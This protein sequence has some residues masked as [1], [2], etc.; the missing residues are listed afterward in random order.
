MTP[1]LAGRVAAGPADRPIAVIATLS[2]QVDGASA[3]P[4]AA[5]RRAMRATARRTQTTVAARVSG[6]VRRFWLVNAIAFS[7]TPR[8]IRAVSADPAVA[9]VALDRAVRTAQQWVP[10]PDAGGGNRGLDTIHAPTAWQRYGVTGAGVRVGVIDTGVNAAHPDLAG[11]VVAWRDFVNGRPAPYDDSGHGTHTAGIIAGG[12]AGG[13]SI[14]VAPGASLVVAKAIG[15][16]GVGSG[17]ALLAAA[18]WMADPDGD[19]AT[20]DHPAVINNSWSSGATSDAWFRTMTARWRQ[21]GITPVFAAGNSGPLGPIASPA[22]YPDVITV[23]ALGADGTAAP[24]SAR[25]PVVWDDPD[26]GGPPAGT[27]LTKPD[28]AAPG[29]AVVSSVG[30]GYLAYS[31]TSVAAPAVS[32]AAALLLQAAPALP[33]DRVAALLRSGA[34][35]IAPA[36]PDGATGHGVLDIPRTLSLAV[37]PAGTTA[38]GREP[39]RPRLAIVRRRSGTATVFRAEGVGATELR[40]GSVRWDFGGGDVTT[41]D[42]ARR[43]FADDARRRVKV[44]A[45][46]VSGTP[47]RTAMTLR[48]RATPLRTMR[49]SRAPRSSGGH[50][51]RIVVRATARR[52]VALGVSLRR[53]ETRAASPAHAT[54]RRAAAESAGRRLARTRAHA[55]RGRFSVSVATRGLAPG[56][57]RVEVTTVRRG[58][59]ARSV[60]TIAIR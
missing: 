16:D 9:Q 38:A 49:V 18:Q 53:V 48:P 30:D 20:A 17:S 59:R 24:F 27:V 50:A 56:V 34:V 11:K 39:R 12:S 21:L 5:V 19:P 54:P 51:A 55:P 42:T 41:A 15:A 46:D 43:A 3:V 2:A 14:G 47:I 29:V 31:G 58:E 28:L 7:G 23:G 4:P 45:Q 60:R 1:E 57:Y 36:G 13:A 26:G 40:P 8:E 32:G 33:P 22:S 6:P 25:G 52:P 44:T 35:D 37:G 10:F